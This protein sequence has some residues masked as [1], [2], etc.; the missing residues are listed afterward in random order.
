MHD[1]IPLWLITLQNL[2]PKIKGLAADCGDHSAWSSYLV[3]V[4]A[5]K[6]IRQGRHFVLVYQFIHL[7]RRLIGCLVCRAL[8]AHPFP[9]TDWMFI[10]FVYIW[11]P[12]MIIPFKP[13]WSVA[14][15]SARSLQ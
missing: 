10:V 1:R 13:L 9:L 2:P 8:A 3:R 7:T 4:Y 6:L 14:R 11:L 15:F 12:Y 5:W